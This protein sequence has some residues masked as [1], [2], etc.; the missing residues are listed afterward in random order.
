VLTAWVKTMLKTGVI[1][2]AMENL[3][4]GPTAVLPSRVT[5][6][7]TAGVAAVVA[8]VVT[9]RITAVLKTVL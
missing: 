1:E 3:T 6:G 7:L 2:D 9:A 8:A 5:T 4:L